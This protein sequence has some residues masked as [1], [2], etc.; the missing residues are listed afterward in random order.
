MQSARDGAGPI[1]ALLQQADIAIGGSRPW[2]IQLHRPGV[3]AEVL[4]G[5]SR[6]L[7]DAYVE[8]A[9]DCEALDEFFTRLILLG[10]DRRYSHGGQGPRFWDRLVGAVLNLQ[11]IQRSTRVARQHYDI[12]SA[13]YQAML[14]PWLQY[15]CGYWE[16]AQSLEA[17]QDDKL[18]MICDKLDLSPGQRLLDIGCGWGGLAAFAARHY[19]VEVVG[20]TL[21]SEQ[22]VFAREHWQERRLRFEL[23]DYRHLPTLELGRV[24]RVVSVGMYEHVGRRNGR[25]FFRCVSEA[26]SDQGLA[27]LQTIGSRGGSG[28][29]DPWINAHVF[30]HGQL[31]SSV[32]LASAFEEHFLLQDWHN[33]GHD[34]DRTL[35]RWNANFAEA[36][37]TLKAGIDADRLPCPVEQ[38]PRFW[39]YYLLC[40]AAFF[41]SG[42]GQLWQLVLSPASASLNSRFP[43]Y[44]SHRPHAAAG[45]PG[46]REHGESRQRVDHRR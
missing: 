1:H 44:R 2:D 43:T 13:V 8:G 45:A 31:P 33:F 39:R 12:P 7:G 27:L 40:C 10:A 3:L 38:F 18:R 36:W 16:F 15:S 37:P 19:G 9:W 23:C 20:I 26:L 25:G 35:M 17:A 4:A 6:V 41:R 30:P 29:T 5:G 14:D 22:L 42:Q 24:D 28:F 11:S 32:D 46:T 34:Y 21:S